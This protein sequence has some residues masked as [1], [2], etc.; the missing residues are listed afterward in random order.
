MIMFCHA[1]FKLSRCCCFCLLALVVV[2]VVVDSAR[3]SKMA[4]LQTLIITMASIL[5]G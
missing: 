1:R 4:C 5:S 3:Y 2:V